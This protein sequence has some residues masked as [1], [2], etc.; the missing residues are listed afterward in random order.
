[1]H[2]VVFNVIGNNTYLSSLK[3]LKRAGFVP[4]YF[5]RDNGKEQYTALYNSNDINEVK[6]A[7]TDFAYLISKQGKYGSYDFAK[8]YRIDDKYLGKAAGSGLGALLGYQFGGIPGLLLGV[9]GGILL[10]ELV[11]IQ[12]GETLV[13]VMNWP[14]Q[15]VS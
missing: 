3:E 12:L 1:M 11:D 10:G 13:G 15:L 6:E 14:I 5:K 2:K 8:I 4:I 7:I 9:I